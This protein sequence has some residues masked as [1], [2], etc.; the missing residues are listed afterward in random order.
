MPYQY[1]SK[2]KSEFV[3]DPAMKR[4]FEKPIADSTPNNCFCK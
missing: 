3:P 4:F 1:L 2:I